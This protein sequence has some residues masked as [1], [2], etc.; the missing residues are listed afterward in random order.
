MRERVKCPLFIVGFPRSGTTL[1]R[2]LLDAHPDVALVNEPEIIRAM[3]W[4][5]LTVRST[6]A[7]GACP[8]LYRH[9]TE[10]GLCRRHLARLPR[11]VLASCLWCR[12][13]RSFRQLYE[14]LLPRAS[15]ALVWGEK[16]L[17]NAFFLPSIHE[18]YPSGLV[19]EIVRDPRGALLSYYRKKL[20]ASADARPPFTRSAVR[21]FA[22]QTLKWMAWTDVVGDATARLPSGF[23]LRV[24]YEQL[25]RE[26]AAVLARLC[27][28]LG[29][30][31]D[32][33]MLALERRRADPVVRRDTDA[34]PD[35]HRKLVRPIDPA[36]AV[37]WRRLPPWAIAVVERLAADHLRRFHYPLTGA[38]DTPARRLRVLLE[39]AGAG[40][41]W[42][43]G[44]DRW[45]TN[46]C[47]GTAAPPV[48]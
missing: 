15:G 24:A 17:G 4:S 9:L 20:A 13:P 2:A 16:S 25:V 31:Y 1:L 45:L 11:A 30:D 48:A 6:L 42:R 18:M 5:G 23:V 7:P 34:E 12:K 19:V 37:V 41:R 40:S 43:R 39:F 26:P 28:A 3:C 10:V 33:G 22:R 14:C 27:R 44:V 29:I 46:Y 38:R 21:F 47:R 36:N 35:A 8:D 32:A